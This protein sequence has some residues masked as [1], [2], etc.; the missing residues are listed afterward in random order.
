MTEAISANQMY[1]DMKQW[2]Q[3]HRNNMTSATKLL[4]EA[5]Y[6]ENP[7]Q[8]DPEL[9]LD[10]YKEK[11]DEI[12]QYFDF[13]QGKDV[14]NRDEYKSQL[15]I[16]AQ[17]EFSETDL[18][19]NGEVSLGEYTESQLK[20]VLKGDDDEFIAQVKATSLLM[21][22]LMDEAMGNSDESGK[23]SKEEY[24]SFYENLDKF[25][26]ENIGEVDGKLDIETASTMVDFLTTNMFTKEYRD[27]VLKNCRNELQ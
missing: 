15:A 1:V 6:T 16:L 27:I 20:G 10:A 17:G 22:R 26:G 23:L 13:M 25:D 11:Y 4:Q 12:G 8:I 19:Q 21:F 7:R 5:I 18:N 9:V 24:M 14:N 3:S 2:E